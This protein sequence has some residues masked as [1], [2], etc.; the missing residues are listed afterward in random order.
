VP[1]IAHDRAGFGGGVFTCG[2]VMFFCVWCGRPSRSLWQALCVSGTIGFATAIGVHPVI[3]YTDPAH[4]A[5]AVFG[6]AIFYT[7][8]VLTF[9]PMMNADRL[10]FGTAAAGQ[11]QSAA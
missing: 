7:G 9:K 8:L 10:V 3:G 11:V 1:L 5:P 4:L 2:V 6:A